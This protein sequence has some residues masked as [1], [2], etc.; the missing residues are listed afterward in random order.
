VA[1]NVAAEPLYRHGLVLFNQGAFYESHEEWEILWREAPPPEKFFLQSLI[2]F[3]VALCHWERGNPVGAQRQMDKCL[4]KLAGYLPRH[5]G[6]D[7]WAVWRGAQAIAE[8]WRAG[9]PPP[10]PPPLALRLY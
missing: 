8:A 9:A 4:R 6:L 10:S 7:T 3:A 2:H 1:V 5:A